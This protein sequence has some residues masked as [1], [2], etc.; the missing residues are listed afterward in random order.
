MSMS[1]EEI[2]AIAIDCGLRVHKDVGPGLLESAY[3]TILA[4][5]LMKRGQ[6]VNTQVIVP[7]TYDGLVIDQG[8]R[9]DIIV[10]GK[11]LLEL[12]SVERLMPIHGKQVLTYLRFLN[13][14][15]G[16][17]M[18]FSSDTFREGLKR[19]VH[20]HDQTQSSRLKIHQ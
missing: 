4:H 15:I 11:V 9:A 10:E 18:N 2:A 3:E 7:I 12:K 17:L 19:V 13:L 6:A 14:P 1:F 8:F 5:L 20:N 16:L